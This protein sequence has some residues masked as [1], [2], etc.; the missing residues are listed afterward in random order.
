MP[1][2]AGVA[3]GAL[4]L[5]DRVLVNMDLETFHANSRS[6]VEGTMY[7]DQV[8]SDNTLDFFIAFSSI[9]TT[10]GNI[11]QMAYT[12][13]NMFMKAIVSQRRQRGLAGSVID[14]SQV[15]GVGYFERVMTAQ[16]T[17]SREQAIRLVDKSGAMGMSEADLHQLFAE[18]IVAGRPDSEADPDIIT[19][20][21]TVTSAQGKD[22]FWFKNP[23]L[24]HFIQ[25]AMAAEHPSIRKAT[26]LPVKTQLETAK[27]VEEVLAILTGK[28]IFSV[29]NINIYYK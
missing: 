24:G 10:I 8:F 7:L 2:I 29:T 13:A 1:P 16:N 20:I 18:A 4:V 17:M 23:R 27:D 25:D 9:S 11:G 19:G 6:K 22:T 21:K 12:A 14:I 3:N 15:I 28:E 26:A 5:V